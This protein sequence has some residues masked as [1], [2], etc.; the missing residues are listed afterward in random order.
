VT[1]RIKPGRDFH[2]R[3]D[4]EYLRATTRRFLGEEAAIES[5]IVGELPAEP[6]GKF[7]FSRSTVAPGFLVP[8]K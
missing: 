5:D 2:T 1:Y 8:T 3:H 6:S 4:L 7:L